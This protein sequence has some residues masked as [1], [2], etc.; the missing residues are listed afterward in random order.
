LLANGELE[1]LLPDHSLPTTPLNMLMV[2]ERA[3]VGRVRLMID[4]LAEH[5]RQLPGMS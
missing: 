3:K 1:A 4:Y 2:P 5:I